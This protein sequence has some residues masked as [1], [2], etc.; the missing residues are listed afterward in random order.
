MKNIFLAKVRD[1]GDL[2][3][4]ILVYKSGLGFFLWNLTGCFYPKCMACKSGLEG[5]PHTRSVERGIVFAKRGISWNHGN[6]SC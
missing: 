1:T 3:R 4:V 6:I 5:A 2:F